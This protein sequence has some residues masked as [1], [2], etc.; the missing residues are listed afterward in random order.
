[1]NS[2]TRGLTSSWQYW[3][4]AHY[5]RADQRGARV[6]DSHGELAGIDH[7]AFENPDGRR[8]LVITNQGEQQQIQCQMGTQALDLTLEQD[9]ATTV[10]L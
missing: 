7:V 8:I 10:L 9:S 2:K 3:A 4:F 5:S 6:I 1:V